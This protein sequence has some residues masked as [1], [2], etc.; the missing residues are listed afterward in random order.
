M[1]STLSASS[2]LTRK[3]S[4]PHSARLVA[5]SSAFGIL[6]GLAV[7]VGQ[8]LWQRL[9]PSANGASLDSL[10]F[11]A[12]PMATG[13]AAVAAGVIAYL[14]ARWPSK[15]LRFLGGMQRYAIIGI[16]VLLVFILTR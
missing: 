15:T 8:L 5:R 12:L 13:L 10:S 2:P 4:Q 1:K 16:V 7:I 11:T 3:P 9:M 6:V 14:D